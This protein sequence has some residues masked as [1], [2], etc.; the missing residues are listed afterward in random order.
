MSRF[1][2]FARAAYNRLYCRTDE[3]MYNDAL[4]CGKAGFAIGYLY[5]A[6]LAING[7]SQLTLLEYGDV[8]L[9]SASLGMFAGIGGSAS[10]MFAQYVLPMCSVIAL[11]FAFVQFNKWREHNATEQ[12]KFARAT[13]RS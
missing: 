4:R 6:H 10:A 7:R 11:P 5:T 9:I 3:Q 8:V 2:R 13:A 12:L 1:N